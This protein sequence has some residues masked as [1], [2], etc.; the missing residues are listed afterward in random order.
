MRR[1]PFRPSRDLIR[2]ASTLAK[3]PGTISAAPRPALHE[4]H[5]ATLGGTATPS[6][7]GSIPLSAPGERSMDTAEASLPALIRHA[8]RTPGQALPSGA[9]Q[10]FGLRL[11]TDFSDVRIHTS[12][13]A[14][15]VAQTLQAQA[16]T[17]GHDIVFGADQYRP[18]STQGQHLLAHELAHVAQPK[19]SGTPMLSHPG[20]ASER[21]ADQAADQVLQGEHVAPKATASATVQR[22]PAPAAQHATQPPLGD[23]MLNNASPFM[24]AA[25]GSTTLSDFDTGKAVL[26][27]AHLKEL[28]KTAH[29]IEQ[30]LRQYPQSTLTIIGHTDTVGT[31]EHNLQLGQQRADATADALKS[32]GVPDAIMHT[33]SVGEGGAQ[34]VKTKDEIPHAQNRR[35]EVRFE[36]KEGFHANLL[37]K[38][39]AR[40]KDKPVDFFEHPKPRIDL[41]YHPPLGLENKPPRVL[42][43]ALKPLPPDL[44]KPQA[45]SAL[46]IVCKHVVD[47]VIDT[48]AHALPKDVRDKLKSAARD[49]VKTGVAKMARMAAE[50]AGLKDP[51]GLDAIEKATEAAIQEKGRTP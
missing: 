48:V 34:A 51:Q 38:P 36:L 28:G 20:D 12:D 41:T 23:Q 10:S 46:D 21:E 7:L 13:S 8:T 1:S 50:G 40:A 44:R 15:R 25:L 2:P 43:A 27:P 39:E 45:N 26:K 22:S 32:L 14:A 37:P 47:P 29:N 17:V 4:P 6:R 18:D 9:R 33:T 19:L 31:E 49:G 11:N 3:K 42:D 30:L 35:V 24:A 5:V 16:F